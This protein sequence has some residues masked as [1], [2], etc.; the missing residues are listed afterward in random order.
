MIDLTILENKVRQRLV[1]SYQSYSSPAL[2]MGVNLAF[3][4]LSWKTPSSR[5]N[6]QSVH[7]D[8]K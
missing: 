7:E 5:D 8:L 2:E 1:N 3:F 4:Q 6:L